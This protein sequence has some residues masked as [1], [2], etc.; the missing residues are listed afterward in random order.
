MTVIPIFRLFYNRPTRQRNRVPS[1]REETKC[2]EE[3][4]TMGIL[5]KIIITIIIGLRGR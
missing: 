1:M 2:L 3:T 5:N 4:M